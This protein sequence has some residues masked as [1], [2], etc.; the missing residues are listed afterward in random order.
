M[1]ESH[2]LTVSPWKR[3]G[4]D[5]LYV[6]SPAG[7]K[8]AWLD[9]ATGRITVLVEERRDDA[10]RALAP[11]LAEASPAPVDPVPQVRSPAVGP[12]PGDDLAGNRPG[13]AL[14]A[15]LAEL[16]PSF[17]RYLL[18]RLLGRASEADSWRKGLRGEQRAGAE[19][20]RLAASGWR[21]L[22]SIPLPR[23]VDIDH[24]LIGP[25]GVFSFNTKH[26]SGA[27]I[28]VGDDSVKIADRSYPYVRKSRAEARRAS[29]ALTRACG[30]PVEVSPVLAFVDARKVVVVPSL[31][32]V[33]VVRHREIASMRSLTGVW[34][35]A[36]VESIY[37]TAR[38]RR[39]W[40]RARAGSDG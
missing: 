21:V 11:H 25:G 32:D 22:H 40:N 33:R 26:H 20:E 30:F 14:L 35:A 12:R 28:W 34:S 2:D 23:E 8:I 31:H 10:L 27:H 19:L 15:K 36:G 1:S 17:W 38:D 4:H 16:R 18:T 6:N 29:A 5:R 37:T 24:L 3:F 7:E 13:E 39:T 9:R